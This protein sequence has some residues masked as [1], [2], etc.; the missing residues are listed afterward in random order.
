MAEFERLYILSVP[1]HNVSF[2]ETVA[3]ATD[4]MKRRQAGG[5]VVTPNLDFMYNVSRDR[6]LRRLVCESD[7]VIADG[8]PAVW[9]SR[10]LGPRLKERVTG[11]DLTP[12]LLKVCAEQGFSVFAIGGA[13]GV[14]EKALERMR[15]QHPGLKIAGTLSPPMGPFEKMDLQA[16]GRCVR[17]ASPHLILVAMGMGKQEKL[18]H[19]LRVNTDAPLMMGVGGSL[20]F[21]A[22]VQTRA[23][24]W[25]QRLGLE[26]VWRLG[27]DPKRFIGRYYKDGVWLLS[28]LSQL[29]ATRT[30]VAVFRLAR[31]L[32]GTAGNQGPQTSGVGDDR[33]VLP[34]PT[35]D[36]VE[37]QREFLE[38]AGGRSWR[39]LDLRSRDW[40]NSLELGVL[41]LLVLRKGKKTRFLLPDG[42]LCRQ[43]ACLGLLRDLT[44]NSGGRWPS[45]F[46]ERPGVWC[47]QKRALICAG[48]AGALA[49]GCFAAA[50]RFQGA[51]QRLAFCGGSALLLGVGGARARAAY[52]R[53]K[54]LNS[55]CAGVQPGAVC[56]IG[57]DLTIQGCS[58]SVE[59]L[60]GFSAEEM[61]G[62]SVS[63]L[64]TSEKPFNPA[65]SEGELTG[66]RKSGLAFPVK[67]ASVPVEGASGGTLLQ[68]FDLSDRCRAERV[69]DQMR[70]GR[71]MVS[72]LYEGLL[73][74]SPVLSHGRLTWRSW[75][76]P[77]AVPGG[78][79]MGCTLRNERQADFVVGDI[80]GKNE[81]AV[82]LGAALKYEVL[83]VVNEHVL[84]LFEN[85]MPSV[86]SLTRMIN[87]A[88]DR[89]LVNIGAYLTIGYFRFDFAAMAAE[90]VW[91][92]APPFFHYSRSTG[93][94]QMVQGQGAAIGLQIRDYIQ[95][96][97]RPFEEGDF[98]VFCS[99]GILF[100]RGAGGEA[101][102][103]ERIAA[104]IEHDAR[105]G[106]AA[107]MLA[108]I[109]SLC[110][111][112][113]GGA[114][115]QDDMACLV[116]CVQGEKQVI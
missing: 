72:E 51:S 115:S 92:G 66:I 31:A 56:V 79:F 82:L 21:L 64:F 49:L 67:F 29:L 58:D 25:V 112:W 33:S 8:M 105:R 70:K 55:V 59:G 54:R 104:V 60:F 37:A 109:R 88:I 42:L 96:E 48:L 27:T 89:R 91:R 24:R 3:W 5:V 15:S 90:Y 23:P 77:G 94:V 62:R 111:K 108:A 99:D 75:I 17:E 100:Q 47:L 14:A 40:L 95:V 16:I 41:S 85:E 103:A 74:D 46:L 101:L 4:R 9:L 102:G 57:P 50:G 10:L 116:A 68:L 13:P 18:M 78:D 45:F 84:T 28:V 43:L 106:D 34:L 65:V 6:E 98:F 63:L 53:N 22:G 86:M 73:E 7:L 52:V 97:A 11:S 2:E 32:R 44:G 76:K 26:W 93:H 114:P 81:V 83:R 1:F 113:T 39:E 61:L 107:A 80:S 35:I 19:W 110:E 30:A 20:D 12:A 69:A 36:T 71:A 38:A 87:T